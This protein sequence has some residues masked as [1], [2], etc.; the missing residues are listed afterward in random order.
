MKKIHYL[1]FLLFIFYSCGNKNEQNNNNAD[2]SAVQSQ[3]APQPPS[4]ENEGR[5]ALNIII[6]Q[7]APSY[8]TIISF[9][10]T[11]GIDNGNTYTM[12]FQSDLMFLKDATALVDGYFFKGLF[13]SFGKIVDSNINMSQ[14]YMGTVNR[15]SKDTK[16]KVVGSIEFRKTENG[17]QF[18]SYRIQQCNTL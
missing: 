12:E 16:I 7:E 14:Q 3:P 2:N 1:F 8:L 15:V 11:N 4:N 13:F 5:Q 9:K 10:K 6:S 18:T 17:L